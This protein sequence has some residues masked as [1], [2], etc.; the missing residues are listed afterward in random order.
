MNLK[1]PSRG[2]G[3]LLAKKAGLSEASISAKRAKGK[4]DKEILEEGKRIHGKRKTTESYAA[5]QARKETALATIREIEVSV[6]RR[7]LVPIGKIN[8]FV[9]GM[10]IKAREE[11]LRIAPELRDR[12]AQEADPIA[13]EQ[14]VAAR[15]QSAL[16][17][18]AEYRGD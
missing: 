11:L 2:S 14:L 12:L 6:K 7:E 10:I 8:A 9:A 1:R 4:T 3:K 5:A 17:V 15:I 16:N 18:L 13:C